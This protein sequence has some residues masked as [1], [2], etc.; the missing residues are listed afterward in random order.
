[1]A[2]LGISELMRCVEFDEQDAA[3]LRVL[4]THAPELLPPTLERFYCEFLQKHGAGSVVAGGT[5]QANL[6]RQ[7]LEEWLAGLFGGTYDAAYWAGR[8]DSGRAHAR[9]GLAQHHMVAAMQVVWAELERGVH[10]LQLPD[11]T[12]KLVSLHKLLMLELAMMLESYQESYAEQIRHGEREAVQARLSEAQ[13]LAQIG[14]LAA[15]LA[16]EIKNPLAGI[17]G[18][19]Q[20]IRDSLKRDDAHR[21]VLD[22]VLRQVSRLD[23]TVKD[24]L[25]Y[26]RPKPPRFRQCDLGQ[27]LSRVLPILREQPEMQRVRFEYENSQRLPTIQADE[28]QLDQ[29]LTNL[30]LNAAQASPTDGLVRLVTTTSEDGVRLTVQDHGHGM[31][32]EVRRRALEPFFT[33]KAKGTGL[34]LPICCKIVEMH[35]GRIAIRSAVAEGT[36]VTVDLPRQQPASGG[37]ADD[38]SRADR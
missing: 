35:G 6:L 16:H 11:A 14:Q 7:T 22:E 38:D 37:S 3:N 20:V 26:A 17:S 8:A 23:G 12:A 1:M 31:D 30:L 15:S 10:R 27:L 9:A 29:L 34:G 4:G 5:P 21:P 28:H 19:I 13:H 36:E 32:E 2:D 24:L 18:A 33:T 25:V